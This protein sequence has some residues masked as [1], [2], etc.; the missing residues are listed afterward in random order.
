M[1][2]VQCEWDCVREIN[3]IYQESDSEAMYKNIRF[4]RS[5]SQSGSYQDLVD[6]EF[7]FPNKYLLI[8]IVIHVTK[9]YLHQTILSIN[10]IL[11]EF[12]SDANKLI[13]QVCGV[14]CFLLLTFYFM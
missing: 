8:R 13:K 9:I 7:C 12:N 2:H 14:N 10:E 6:I 1:N 3:C 11:W 5:I 4:V